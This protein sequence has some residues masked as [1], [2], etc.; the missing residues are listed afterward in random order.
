MN[1]TFRI[2]AALFMILALGALIY[3]AAPINSP[4][5]RG[6]SLRQNQALVYSAANT[7][8]S[9]ALGAAVSTTIITLGASGDPN[10]DDIYAGLPVSL[11]GSGS[12]AASNGYTGTGMAYTASTKRLTIFPAAAGS[13][14]PNCSYVIGPG[15]TIPVKSLEFGG[16][17][18]IT[19]YSEIVGGS[20]TKAAFQVPAGAIVTYT[21]AQLADLNKS[22]YIE[23]AS[24]NAT[25]TYSIHVN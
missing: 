13:P 14:D 16:A 10:R 23:W 22:R 1:K 6:I 24:A 11:T 4:Q 21:P 15:L 19:Y 25:D 3:G 2:S 7:I 20:L 8:A 9:E 17:A 18:G 12:C 5:R